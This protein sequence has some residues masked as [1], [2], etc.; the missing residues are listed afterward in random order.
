MFK[1]WGLNLEVAEEIKSSLIINGN[2]L[3]L[4]GK[5]SLESENAIASLLNKRINA[6]IMQRC[7][8]GI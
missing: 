2:A 8:N 3:I 5:Y 4:G 7:P 1:L 6:T